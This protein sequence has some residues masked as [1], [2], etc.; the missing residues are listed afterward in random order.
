MFVQIC[1]EHVSIDSFNVCKF[2][3]FDQASILIVACIGVKLA[4]MF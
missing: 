4:A 3:G 1:I 2:L